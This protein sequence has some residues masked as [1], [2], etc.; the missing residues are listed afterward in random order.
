M[1]TILI[2]GINGIVGNGIANNLKGEFIIYGVG[3]QDSSIV[4]GINAYDKLDISDIKQIIEYGNNHKIDHIVHCAAY[5]GNDSKTV[6]DSNILG[7]WNIYKLGKL[8]KCKSIVYISG[9]PII[10]MPKE[11]PITEKHPLDP[12]SNYHLSKYIGELMLHNQQD[13]PV[14]TLRI[15]SP[16]VPGMPANTILP[17]YVKKCMTNEQ[18][19]VMGKGSR[20]QN[21]IDIEDISLAVK[22]VIESNKTGIYNIASSCSISNSELANTCKTI[23]NSDSEI[24]FEGLDSNE[25]INWDISIEKAKDELYFIPQRSIIQTI[26]S[27]EES[28]EDTDLQ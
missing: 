19:T 1:R 8:L 27:L 12:Q 22:L 25:G 7:T 20:S 28:Y 18:L 13:I 5:K 15:P 4:S 11:L 6:F 24:K 3:R 21:Y 2:T 9:I 14:V 16:I 26:K 17:V 10:G 23:L